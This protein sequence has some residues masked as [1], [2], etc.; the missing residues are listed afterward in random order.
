MAYIK[1]HTCLFSI[2]EKFPTRDTSYYSLIAT[3]KEKQIYFKTMVNSKGQPIVW[4]FKRVYWNCKDNKKDTTIQW[5]THMLKTQ[6]SFT[7]SYQ[8]VNDDIQ[9]L[10]T[11]RLLEIYHLTDDLH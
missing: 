5:L 3:L 7:W 11:Q 4:W 9:E 10:S 2:R 8:D 6:Y 1:N